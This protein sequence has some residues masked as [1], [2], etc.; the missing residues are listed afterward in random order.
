MATHLNNMQAAGYWDVIATVATYAPKGICAAYVKLE[1][2]L[3]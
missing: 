2:L 1:E 3:R